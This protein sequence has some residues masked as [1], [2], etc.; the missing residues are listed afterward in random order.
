MARRAQLTLSTAGGGAVASVDWQGGRGLFMVD[1]TWGGGTVALEQQSPAGV[2][3]PLNHEGT[4]TPI[5]LTANGT[6]NFVS[7]AGAI[8][9]NVTTATAVNAYAVGVP[10][11][12]AG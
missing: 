9:A 6:A 4:S 7:A 1:A 8:R 3:L 10:T 12:N 2:W 5:S 11:N